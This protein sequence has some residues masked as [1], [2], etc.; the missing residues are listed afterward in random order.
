MEIFFQM[1][2]V[3]TKI[4]PFGVW[5]ICINVWNSERIHAWTNI[6]Q[7][8][9]E[10][11][12]DTLQ[13]RHTSHD[14]LSIVIINVKNRFTAFT[15]PPCQGVRTCMKMSVP[16][17]WLN[18]KSILK[19]LTSWKRLKISSAHPNIRLRSNA[20]H[21]NSNE[22]WNSDWYTKSKNMITTKKRADIL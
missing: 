22:S 19:L 18:Y 6:L 16:G 9:V 11:I 13:T 21:R 7:K 8:Y 12:H 17:E 10:N 2:R 3:E 5:F 1:N 14:N 15:L 20:T 4:Y